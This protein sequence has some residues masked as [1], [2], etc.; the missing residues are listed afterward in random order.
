MII[1]DKNTIDFDLSEIIAELELPVR[2]SKPLRPL[3]SGDKID[4]LVLEKTNFNKKN[5]SVERKL[6]TDRLK[7]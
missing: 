4:D 6:K 7:V 1:S 5:F 3:I 2:K